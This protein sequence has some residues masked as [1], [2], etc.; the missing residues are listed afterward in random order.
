MAQSFSIP[1]DAYS[2]RV[3]MGRSLRYGPYELPCL[4][5]A[6]RL[7]VFEV[8]LKHLANDPLL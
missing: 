8:Y 3:L 1:A 4:G 7:T 2:L 5:A 6:H